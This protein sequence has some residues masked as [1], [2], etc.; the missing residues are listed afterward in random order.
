M[1]ARVSMA[2]PQRPTSPS[3][4]GSS[5]S[6]PSS[7]GMSNAV[8]SPSPPR[9]DDLLEPPVGVLG[10][11]EPGEHPHGPQLR[12][13][14]RGVGPTGVRVL[15]GELT[16]VGA[17]HAVERDPRHGRE[18]NVADLRVLDLL[19][20]GGSI[21][22]HGCIVEKSGP[23]RRQGA[24]AITPTGA[25][26]GATEPPGGRHAEVVALDA[27][28]AAATGRAPS[29]ARSSRARTTAAPRRARTRIVAAGVRRVVVGIV[30]PDAQR[31]RARGS[32][33]L[34]AAGID[35]DGRGAGR[36]GRPPARAVPPPP[37]H[38][39][40][41]RG[42]QARPVARRRHRGARRHARSG[43]PA[44]TPAATPTACG[45]RATR[46]SSAPAPSAPTTRR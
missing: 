8:D 31:R 36:R 34:R 30:D 10:G 35:V 21:V 28:G 12:A 19:L 25:G 4:I 1:S 43:S 27:A 17:V 44:P 7:V 11:A 32:N 6:R 46:S 13:V 2:T 9:L 20:P 39:A 38:R 18:R 26:T 37:A 23:S 16:V 15:A 5:E 33:A 42:V 3:D 40:P 29:C 24:R 14:H 41:V 22:S 45:P